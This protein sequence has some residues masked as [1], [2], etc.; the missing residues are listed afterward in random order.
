MPKSSNYLALE[1]QWEMLQILPDRAPGLSA[2]EL[3]ERLKEAGYKVSKRTVERDL[4]QF[5]P[6]FG[7]CCNDKSKPYGWHWIPGRKETFAGVDLADALSL[8]L[9]ESVLKQQLPPSMLKAL[10]PKFQQAKAKLV[11]VSDHPLAKLGEKVRYVPASL[12]FAAPTVSEKVLEQIQD[13]LVREQQIEVR[14]APF[15]ENAKKLRL[16]P[17]C[18]VQRGNVPYLLASTFDY[19]E[20][21]LYA[22]HRVEAVTV[23]GDQIIEPNGFSVDAHLASGAME[24]GG[25]KEITLKAKLSHQLATY[26]AETALHP[27]QKMSHRGAGYELTARVRDS[28][29]LHF[30]IMSQGA[31]IEVT[32]P[33]ALRARVRSSL[34]AALEQYD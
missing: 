10:Q 18:L 27:D 11:A 4:L 5:E 8:T 23:L 26:L 22:L 16:H 12:Q 34:A 19:E 21:L 15:N 2:R 32:G 13:A 3:T 1:R 29:Q 28:W 14:Y 31:D 6:Q 7:I 17:L 9:A 30:W 25:G 24:F 33:K 20:V